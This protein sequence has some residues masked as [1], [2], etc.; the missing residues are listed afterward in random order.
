MDIWVL[1][2]VAPPQQLKN[3]KGAEGM[4]PRARMKSV[5]APDHGRKTHLYA[6]NDA[7]EAKHNQ[8]VQQPCHVP[9]RQGAE[10]LGLPRKTGAMVGGPGE[11]RG[12]GMRQQG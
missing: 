5:S 7:Q 3:A 6:G 8:C 2:P 11:Q 12:W 9:Q 1:D 4:L 10:L